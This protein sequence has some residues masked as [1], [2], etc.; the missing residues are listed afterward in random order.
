MQGTKPILLVED[1][2]VDAMKIER[3]FREIDVKNPLIKTTDGEEALLYLRGKDN[4][5]PCAI[6]LD[7]KMPLMGGIEFLKIIK[8][9]E[10]LKII[11]V[12]VLTTSKDEQ[13]K[14]DSFNLSIAGYMLKQ[15]DYKQF[16][17]V[18]K[19]INDYWSVSEMPC[20]ID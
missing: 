2:E 7:L 6:I 13:D 4:E 12:I 18:I 17:E 9:D 16:L 14:I 10:I 11:P 19:T 8:A 20:N 1:D 5:L 3:A 15:P